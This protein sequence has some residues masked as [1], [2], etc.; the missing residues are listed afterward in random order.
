[1]AISFS[2]LRLVAVALCAIC[3]RTESYAADEAPYPRSVTFTAFPE[4]KSHE[5][6]RGEEVRILV[7]P[8][9]PPDAPRLRKVRH[10]QA[11]AGLLYLAQ[12]GEVIR[13]GAWNTSFLNDAILMAVEAYTVAAEVEDSAPDRVRWYEERVRVLKSLERFIESRVEMGTEAP[14]DL[15]F[16]RFFRYQAEADLLRL[17]DEIARDGNAK[18]R[19]LVT[20]SLEAFFRDTKEPTYTAFPEFQPP[21]GPG[22]PGGK[23]D[24]F[25][26]KKDDPW[27]GLPELATDA[28]PLRKIQIALACAGLS[29][30]FCINEII[31]I[32]SWADMWSVYVAA[33]ANLL[34]TTLAITELE[35][36]ANRMPWYERAVVH[37]KYYERA[38]K[39]RVSIGSVA[40]HTANLLIFRRLEAEARLLQ[41]KDEIT[42]SGA[43]P[44]PPGKRTAINREIIRANSPEIPYTAFPELKPP[45]IELQENKD[46]HSNR[47]PGYVEKNTAP[48]PPLP[49][50]MA[51]DSPLRKVLL[52]QVREGLAYLAYM[53]EI[54]SIGS[55]NQTFFPQ[56]LRITNDVFRVAAE[57]EPAKRMPW[58]ETR[59]RR[60]KAV[61]QFMLMRVKKG[62]APPH[63]LDLASFVRLQAEVDLLKLKA[64]VEPVRQPLAAPIC[65][66]VYCPPACIC[67]PRILPRLFRR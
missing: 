29:H 53:K 63:A 23:N 44:T 22:D 48:L 10:A 43:K 21:P 56:Y 46:P 67:R 33:A 6:S 38:I 8:E 37:M 42:K 26:E 50:L 2:H 9:L 17:K 11:T 65:Q 58:Y 61:E 4:L 14:H 66:P 20:K 41:L 55:W 15:L 19:P 1:M 64:E 24:P 18:S 27:T 25:A 3:L 31:R 32:G 28:A 60:L 40:P 62:T 47:Y 35:Q 52:A 7:L 59:I 54:I 12:I 13:C 34:N 30:Q 49:T 57:L 5:F 16:T 36:I 45:T 51:N 39:R